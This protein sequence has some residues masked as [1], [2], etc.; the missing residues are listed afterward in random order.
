MNNSDHKKIEILVNN[1]PEVYQPIFGHPN[2][3]TKVSRQCE[4]RLIEIKKIYE[5]FSVKLGR[6]LKVLDLG[7]SQGFFSFSLASLGAS[8]H[9]IDFLSVNVDVCQALAKEFPKLKVKFE[10][11][12]IEDFI[13][14]V[15]KDEYD[16]V[17]GLSVF[18]HLI[19]EY[20]KDEVS[21][22]IKKIAEKISVGIFEVALAEEPLYWG[23]AQHKDPRDLLSK[24]AFVHEISRIKTHLSDIVRPLYVASNN[25]WMLNDQIGSFESWKDES[26]FLAGGVHKFT[27]RYFFGKDLLVKMYLIGTEE[28]IGVVNLREYKSEVDF[29]MLPN[30]P[31]TTPKLIL[32]GK[33]KNEVWLVREQLAGKLLSEIIQSN[34]NYDERKVVKDI[35]LQLVELEKKGLYHNDVRT[36]NIIINPKGEANLID[37]G[38]ISDQPNDCVWPDNIF[39]SFFIFIYEV[40]NH[41]IINPNP[42]RAP[43]LSPLDLKDPYKSV[44][45]R[46]LSEP[47]EKLS[48]NYLYEEFFDSKKI[49]KF[50]E[51]KIPG[52]ILTIDI[53]Q[54]KVLELLDKSRQDTN[55]VNSGAVELSLVRAVLDTTKSQLD[56]TKS[57]LDTTKSQLDTTKSQLDTTKSQLDSKVNELNT[58]YSSRGWRI[59]LLLH[60]LV[61]VFIPLGSKRRKVFGFVWKYLKIP[62]KLFVRVVRKMKNITIFLFKSS[63]TKTKQVVKP[64]ISKELDNLSPRARRIYNDLK[65]AIEKRSKNK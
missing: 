62:F 48:F 9:G 43:L 58:I 2:V 52:S 39:L 47:I 10:T 61:R 54:K 24:Y 16:L 13:N 26:H 21:L 44:M 35:L 20:G 65:G 33:N 34:K 64:S 59:I 11:A 29:L 38:S 7:S 46:L 30:V 31:F 50:N 4:D 1:L 22:I 36:W 14:K 8:V 23:L 32:C 41:K 60:K 19:H 18:H 28:H 17:L 45:I 56:T 12:R 27:R 49:F 53:F 5:L 51:L 6:S 63:V 25:F 42:L 57:Q 15:K 37:F 55:Q 3:S 40:L